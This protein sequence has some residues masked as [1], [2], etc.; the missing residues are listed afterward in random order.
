MKVSVIVWGFNYI[1]ECK[2]GLPIAYTLQRKSRLFGH[3]WTIYSSSIM[4]MQIIPKF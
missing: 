4:M 1:K 3:G 2:N